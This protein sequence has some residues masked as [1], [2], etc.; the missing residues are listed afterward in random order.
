MTRFWDGSGISWTIC[1]QSAPRS[2]QITTPTPHHSSFTGRMLFLMPNQPTVSLYSEGII[3]T[4]Q[5][6]MLDISSKLSQPVCAWSQLCRDPG[7]SCWLV[8]CSAVLSEQ[9]VQG[10]SGL[11]IDE[12]SVQMHSLRLSVKHTSFAFKTHNYK[13]H[14]QQPYSLYQKWT[15]WPSKVSSIFIQMS[16]T[17]NKCQGKQAS[18]QWP[19]MT[20]HSQVFDSDA[21]R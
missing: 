10:G 4:Q 13:T 2:R 9:P 1:K 17:V 20:V 5:K 21:L 16:H 19:A 6:L 8:P 14:N 7:T 12:A 18:W 3:I 11:C 15:N